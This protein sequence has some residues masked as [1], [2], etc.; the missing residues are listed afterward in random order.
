MGLDL[1]HAAV[2]TLEKRTEGWVVGLQLAGLAMQGRADVNSFIA[3]FAGEQAYIIDYLADEVFHQQPDEVQA[4][5]LSTSILN[6]LSGP[7]CDAI[8]SRDEEFAPTAS[9]QELLVY[10]AQ[11]NL[12]II[13]LDDRRQWFGY[14]HLFAGLLRYRLKQNQPKQV[15]DLHQRASAWYASH[16]FVEDALH[17]TMAA[18]DFNHAADLIE[19]VGAD[20]MGQGRLATLRSWVECLP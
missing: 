9:S 18:G 8:L 1:D 7:L 19:S 6:R 17:H 2:T 14:H 11:N 10:L 16:D 5:L 15:S 12:F 20:M 4:F 13:P 3:D